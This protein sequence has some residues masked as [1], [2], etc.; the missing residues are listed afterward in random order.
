[1]F[2]CLYSGSRVGLADWKGKMED[3]RFWLEQDI[4][5][6]YFDHRHSVTA[7][8]V[9]GKRRDRM[10][11]ME[12]TGTELLWRVSNT[13]SPESDGRPYKEGTIRLQ[14][15]RRHVS[16][17]VP[18]STPEQS[19]Y[20][21]DGH[22]FYCSND[23]RL[24]ARFTNGKLNEAAI[25]HYFETGSLPAD[26]GVYEG[27]KRI[28]PLHKLVFSDDELSIAPLQESW[29]T[30]IYDSFHA[31]EQVD[32][33]LEELLD[34]PGGSSVF[35]SG[36]VDSALIAAK[37]K[38]NGR[39]DVTLENYSFGADDQEAAFA[40]KVAD[41]IGM[42]FH[43]MTFDESRL[44]DVL[45][46]LGKDYTFP[47]V[48]QATL[49]SRLMVADR[50][51]G[52][53]F[54]LA[55]DGTGAD[56]LFTTHQD[57]HSWKKVYKVPRPLRE[58]ARQGYEWMKVSDGDPKIGT[59]LRAFKKSVSGPMFYAMI[60][61][62]NSLDGVGFPIRKSVRYD[63]LESFYKHSIP[64]V[65]GLPENEQL[66]TL[67]VI[68]R[69]SGLSAP[70]I[71]DPLHINGVQTLYPFLDRE[72]IGI[73]ARV[74]KEEKCRQGEQ[75]YILKSMLARYL[76]ES[77]IYRP[78]NVFLP[79][80][81][82]VMRNPEVGKWIEREVLAPSNPLLAY[83]DVPFVTSLFRKAEAGKTLSFDIYN[84]LWGFMVISRWV[85]QVNESLSAGNDSVSFR[86]IRGERH[87][88][89]AAASRLY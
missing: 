65:E 77:F 58:W 62:T 32:R 60:M 14:K 70:K 41:A 8:A 54:P 74:P 88:A 1:M 2:Y 44:T 50:L 35:F 64:L 52:S 66:A 33:R 68:L 59:P 87:H 73:G 34:I 21:S 20:F 75:K 53:P 40:E 13:W 49:Q 84:F 71:H 39:E 19:C 11:P 9:I 42:P 85:E 46:N 61:M 81:Q 45:G 48:D 76:P 63:L 80:F 78:K 24:L 18:L 82:K 15:G 25:Y 38:E 83:V 30:E 29:D 5:Y 55:V 37:L 47:Y 36:G 57:V 86:E 79:P 67:R 28:P 69:A 43:Q 6:M 4:E 17:E 51:S 3:H 23:Q 16:I 72:M 27:V 22:G 10:F 12:D 89:T 31:G 56:Y 7:L 26:Q